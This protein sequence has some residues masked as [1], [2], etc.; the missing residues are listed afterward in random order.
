MI[1][2][3]WFECICGR[4]YAG[5]S[6]GDITSKCHICL[7]ENLPFEIRRGYRADKGEETDKSHFCNACKG[8]GDCPIVEQVKQL[9]YIWF[10]KLKYLKIWS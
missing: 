1:G 6:R 9:Y 2:I 8:K 3:G 4:I 7:T 10:F 5:F